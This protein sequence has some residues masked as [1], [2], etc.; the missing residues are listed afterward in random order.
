[1]SIDWAEVVSW[2]AIGAGLLVVAFLLARWVDYL[3]RYDDGEER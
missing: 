1:M 2:L 3:C